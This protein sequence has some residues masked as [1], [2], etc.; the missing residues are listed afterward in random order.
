MTEID[1]VNKH[2][3]QNYNDIKPTTNLSED[4]D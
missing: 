3:Y 4:N 2:Q 1:D